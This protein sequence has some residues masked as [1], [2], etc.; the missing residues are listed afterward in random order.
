MHEEQSPKHLPRTILSNDIVI[1][2]STLYV[3]IHCNHRIQMG[4]T[5]KAINDIPDLS[6]DVR[7]IVQKNLESS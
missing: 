4:Q 5:L 3:P 7:E 1:R 2:T 6:G